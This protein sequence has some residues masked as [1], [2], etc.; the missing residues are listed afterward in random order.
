M[1][2]VISRASVK[3]NVP[4]FIEEYYGVCRI[5]DYDDRKELEDYFYETYNKLSTDIQAW[6]RHFISKYLKE[7]RINDKRDLGGL[8]EPLNLMLN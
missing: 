2:Q 8:F 3:I 4:K 6:M 5:G 1:G 7:N